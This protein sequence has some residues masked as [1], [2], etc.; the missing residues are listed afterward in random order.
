M[1]Y[2]VKGS[3]RGGT[4]E[5]ASL[6]LETRLEVDSEEP[7]ETIRDYVRAGERCCFTI[8]SLLSPVPVELKALLNGRELS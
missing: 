8:Q 3:W 5:V 6:G 2:S 7:S 1:R 4:K